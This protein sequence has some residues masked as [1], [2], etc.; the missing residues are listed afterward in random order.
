MLSPTTRASSTTRPTIKKK[1]TSVP[2]FR[3]RPAGPKNISEPTNE[4]GMPTVIHIAARRSNTSN[5]R[6]KTRI[7]PASPFLAT[8][9]NRSTA[10]C[11]VSFQTPIA[12]S[13]GGT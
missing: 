7:T 3:V 12:T 5:S 11:A 6:A 9:D 1:P 10:G 13:C 2:M 4:N 8:A